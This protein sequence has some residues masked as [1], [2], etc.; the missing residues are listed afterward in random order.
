LWDSTTSLLLVQ[1]TGDVCRAVDGLAPTTVQWEEQG[2]ALIKFKVMTIRVPDIRSQFIRTS[3]TVTD[4][5][6]GIVHGT[7]A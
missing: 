5:V 7:T 6:C 4:R 1:M 2:G 3:T